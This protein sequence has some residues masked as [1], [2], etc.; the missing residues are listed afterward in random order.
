MGLKEYARKR[1]FQKTPEPPGNEV[2]AHSGDRGGFFCVQRHDASHLHY[3]FRLEVNGVLVSWAVPKG[4]SLDP[5][6]KALAMKVEDHPLDYGTFEGNIPEGNYGAGSVML[7]DKGTYEVLGDLPAQA[8]LDRGDFKFELHGTKLKGA[9]AIVQMKRAQK[10]NEWLLIKKK[11][12]F[13][14]PGYD[15]DKYAWSV[16]SDRTQEEIAANVSP[17]KMEDLPGVRKAALPETI[18]PMLATAV[19]KPP[20]GTRWLYEIKWDGVRALCLIKNRKLH[21]QT[22]RG[23]RCEQQY[24]EFSNLP[25][26][27][28]AK[29]V[30]LDGEICVLDEQGRAR[31]ALIQPR[32]GANPSAVPRLAETTPAT[33]FLFDIL[34]ADG[35]DLRGVPLEERK[36]LLSKLVNAEDPIRI[37]DVFDAE[38]EQMLEA[39]RKME[40]EGI[41]GK[42]RRS[43]YEGGRSTRWLKIKIL[44]EQEFVIAGFTKGERDYFGALILGVYE[45]GELQHAGQV[46]TGFDQKTMKAIHDRLRPLVTKDN[47]FPKKPR[48]KDAVWVKPEVVCQVRFLEWTRDGILRGPVFAGLR[49]DKPPEE[50][51]REKPAEP[52]TVTAPPIASTRLDLSGREAIVE[53]DGHRLKF[54]NLNKVFFPNDGWK[55]RDLLEFYDRVAT[56]L[57]PHLKDRPLSMKR[58]PNGIAG[59][60]FFQKNAASHFPD[61]MRCE[62]ITEHHPP[63][64]N[65]YPIAE[66]RASLLYLVNLG[67][68]DHN[69]WMSRAGNLDHPDWMLLDL[70]P[71]DA[72]FDQIIE[73][74]LIVR[75]VLAEIGLKGYPKTTGG[76]G[77]HVYVPLEPIYTYEQVRSFAELVS[78]LTVDREPNLFTTPRSVEKRKKGRVY[79]DYLQIGT[80]KTIAAPYVVRAH[81]GAP[82]ATPLDWKEVKRGLRPTDF[83]IDNTIERFERVG[84][85]FAPVLEGGQRLEDALESVQGVGE[86]PVKKKSRRVKS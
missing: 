84:D 67:C 2:K 62:P 68:I 5:E 1:N 8:Q 25:E 29:T 52:E 86:E 55:K 21:I 49:E 54:T 64:V 57:L 6:R 65:H 37:S 15:I 47:P 60:F 31:F 14:V 13:V 63:K 51:V 17:A 30:W 80:G 7:W 20:A 85:L 36:R 32:I 59:E 23:N 42:D 33:L 24:P 50:V 70:D 53:V 28:N 46:G 3:D 12:E 73:A 11:D 34:Y 16:A 22:R 40:I 75:D 39:A 78:H 56:W 27:V 77:M 10:G 19:T 83:R 61:W 26:R 43:P 74:M 18:E 35:Y 82:V 9:F 81:D 66:D 72:P 4:P 58:Y 71:V 79:F 41:V 45:K 38:G 69:P 44:G 48:V 76:D